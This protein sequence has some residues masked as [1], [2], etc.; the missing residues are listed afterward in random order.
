MR[1]VDLFR[2]GAPRSVHDAVDSM[3]VLLT[4]AREMWLAATGHLLYSEPLDVDLEER[5]QVVDEQE[6]LIRSLVRT[7]VENN[8][9]GDHKL[10]LRLVSVVQDGE[11]I[12]D[13]AKNIGSLSTLTQKPLIGRHTHLLRTTRDEITRLFDLT[14]DG[15]VGGSTRSAETVLLENIRLK[16]GLRGFIRELAMTDEASVNEAVVLAN[17]ALMMGR[18]SSHLSNI[19]STIVLPYEHIRRSSA[20]D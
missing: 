10:S 5:D 17:C 3:E 4:T 8:P 6:R 2:D 11:R 20:E 14:H 13:L 9:K 18:V 19:A 12:G 15:F 16:A 1:I 7:Y